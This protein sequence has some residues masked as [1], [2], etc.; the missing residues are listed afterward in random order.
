MMQIL[1]GYKLFKLV[2]FIFGITFCQ[3]IPSYRFFSSFQNL[4]FDEGINWRKLS[5]F[6]PID[7]LN[8]QSDSSNYLYS[9]NPFNNSFNMFCIHVRKTRQLNCL[10]RL[11]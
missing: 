3:Y 6:E 2:L 1:K 9:F 10:T 5:V 11:V 7:F 8:S 4:L